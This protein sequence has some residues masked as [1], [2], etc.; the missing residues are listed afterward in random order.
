MKPEV[1]DG[2][3]HCMF[4][5]TK[6]LPQIETIRIELCEGNHEQR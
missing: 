4:Y 3:I 1:F 6:L 5:Y 2:I